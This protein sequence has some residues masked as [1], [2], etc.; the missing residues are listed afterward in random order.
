MFE[1]GQ[2]LLTRQT[3]MPLHVHVTAAQHMCQGVGTQVVLLL[4][5]TSQEADSL[6]RLPQT[7]LICQ[8]TCPTTADCTPQ[9][10]LQSC[11]LLRR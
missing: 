4:H 3:C 7:H 2:R 9:L 6:N 1:V 8:D 10:T 11:Q 5:Q